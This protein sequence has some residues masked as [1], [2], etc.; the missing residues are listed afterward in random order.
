MRG[1]DKRTYQP[2]LMT[3][4]TDNADK[5]KPLPFHIGY[6]EPSNWL[7]ARRKAGK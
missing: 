5:V 7:C 3:A 2:D 4:Y 6:S 1:T